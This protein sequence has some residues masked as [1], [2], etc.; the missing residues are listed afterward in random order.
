[1]HVSFKENAINPM[2][3]AYTFRYKEAPVPAQKENCIESNIN[4]NHPEGFDNV[5]F[6]SKE[7]FAPGTKAALKCAFEGKGCPEIILVEKSELCEDGV[8]RYG[9]CF[10]IVL[11]KNGVNVWRHFM[12]ENYKCSWHKRVGVDFPVTENEI[13]TLTVETKENYIIFSVDGKKTTL[14]TEDLFSSF[15]IGLTLC[16]GVARAYEME[17]EKV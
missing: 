10:E 15:H 5:S 6:L 13:H 3:R 17:Y 12:D 4:K 8:V 1:M 9:A 16:E 7:T 2:T 14:R 11:Y